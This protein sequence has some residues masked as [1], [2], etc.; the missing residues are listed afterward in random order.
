VTEDHRPPIGRVAAPPEHESTSGTFYFWVDKQCGVERTQI[1]TTTSAVGSRTV[2]FVGIVQEVYRRS[3]QKDV[4]E[5]AARFDGRTGE[6][7]MFDSEGVTY[8]EVAILRTT[9]V[10]HTPPTEESEVFLATPQEARE[11]YGVDRMKQRLDVGLLKNGGTA[12]AGTAAID[13]AFLLGEN[14]GHLNVNGIAGLGTKSTLLLTMNWLLLREVDRQLRERPGDPKRL[15]VVPVI[16]NVKNFDLFFI[17]RWNA[18]FRRN[19]SEHRSDRAAMGV[20][21]PKPFDAPTFFAPQ[22]KGLSTPVSTGGRIDGVK[23]YSWSLADIIEQRLFLFL[24]SDEDVQDA[25][26]GGLVGEMEEYLTS[27]SAAGPK[28]RKDVPRTFQELLDW[29]REERDSLFTD[30][31][32]GTKGKLLRRLK[33]VVMEGDG[34]LRRTDPK[35]SPLVIP[36]V[37]QKAPIVI[38]LCGIQDTPS[39][40]RFVVAAVFHQIQQ[41][42]RAKQTPNLKYLITLDELNRFAPKDSSD[43]IT[44]KLEAIASE[45]RSQGII[46]F[47]AQQ[48]ASL[49]KSRVIENAAVRAVGRSGTLELGAEVWK[50]LGPSAR[51]AAAQLQPDE[52]LLYLPSFREP[53]LAKIPFPPF[54]LSENDVDATAPPAGAPPAPRFDKIIADY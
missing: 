32:K 4:T 13:L 43:P 29:F 26:F 10:A 18:E 54:A 15:Q 42:Q 39:L 38:D 36:S 11:G 41:T 22:A 24:F 28:L 21:D 40:Q 30:F 33:F 45:G 14:G 12:F 47:G 17:D 53:M 46:L 20:S 25:N 50:F 37:G 27:E 48:Q 44:Q 7:P 34:V 3:R 49:V 23:P 1:V 8:A 2:K 19:E 52:K 31:V 35:G 51:G 6:R 16:F 9:P 5:E